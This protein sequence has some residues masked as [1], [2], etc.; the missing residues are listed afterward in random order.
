MLDEFLL[1]LLASLAYDL[2]KA[3]STRF[4]GERDNL[5]SELRTEL[6]RQAQV[7]DALQAVLVRLGSERVVRI[8]GSVSNSV[9]ITGNGNRVTVPDDGALA[10][11]W[12][13]LHQTSDIEATDLY[14]QRLAQRYAHLAFPL[15]GISFHALLDQ[16]YQPL[17]A[18]PVRDLTN[19]RQAERAD[20]RQRC[21][22]DDLLKEGPVALLGALGGGKTTTLHYLTWA[23]A[24][25]SENRLLWR[26]DELIPF[27]LTAHD[28]AQAWQN[29]TEF[30]TA[31]TRAMTRAQRHPF[32]SPYLTYRVLKSALQQGTALL[33]I[34]ALDEYRVPDTLR[35]D[36]LL[37]VHNVW[38]NEPFRSNSLMV[39]SRPQAFLDVGLRAY[40]LQILE[41]PRAEWLAYRLGKA[42]LQAQGESEAEQ[43]IKLNALTR[44]VVSPPMQAFASPF[45]VTLLTLAVCRSVH[46]ASSLEQAQG[47]GNLANL[48]HF[49][50]RQTIRWEQ[51]KVDV[52]PVD[53][54]TALAALADLGWKISVEPPWQD[55]L[56]Q[57]LISEPDRRSALLFWQHT[58]LLQR[59]EFSGEWRFYHNGF[60]L[61]GAALMLNEAWNRGQQQTVNTLHRET[62]SLTDW[63]TIW[64]LFFGLRGKKNS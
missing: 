43:Q 23:Y 44:L 7:L 48:Y 53:E 34:D 21:E 39:T 32:C 28:L 45:Y 29:E 60:Q 46:F 61:F 58:G 56:A 35:R 62:F 52:P 36:L 54:H 31:C 14:R 55:R 59:D 27:Y 2:L 15:S 5:L 40:I 42:L 50:L 24:Y 26:G 64:Q 11:R 63:E 30:T 57:D 49:F 17:Q 4:R 22:T 9:I 41:K 18:A 16:V 37:G 25:R 3:L 33:L 10:Q 12:Q 13:E 47:I 6:R 38:Q 20:S 1:N 19:W 51:A 8:E